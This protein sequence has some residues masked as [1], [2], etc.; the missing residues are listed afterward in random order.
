[1]NS[2]NALVM[3]FIMY[4]FAI[5]ILNNIV[6]CQLVVLGE[7]TRVTFSICQVLKHLNQSLVKVKK[8]YMHTISPIKYP[9]VHES[10]LKNY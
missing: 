7:L 8:V 3:F 10:G 4:K 1:M 9:Y 6:N 2:F 5:F